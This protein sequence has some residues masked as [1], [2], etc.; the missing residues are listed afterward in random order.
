MFVPLTHA[1]REERADFGG[2]ERKAHYRVADLPHSGYCFVAAFQAR[3]EGG[4]SGR[5]LRAFACFG[6]GPRGSRM[7]TRGSRWPHPG[8]PGASRHWPSPRL[9]VTTCWHRSP[10]VW[11]KATIMARSK[12]SSVT[13][14]GTAWCR[15][16]T[17]AIWR[18]GTRISHKSAA[19]GANAWLGDTPPR[20]IRDR[21]LGPR[22]GAGLYLPS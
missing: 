9:R 10:A 4:V 17:L 14:G 3:D 13:L 7:T 5:S 19:G 22:H 12:A 16:R 6:G 15:S 18:N 8:P 2:V 20:R 21:R 1:P 11:P